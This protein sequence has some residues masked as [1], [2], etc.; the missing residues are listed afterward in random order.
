MFYKVFYIWKYQR[1]AI[2]LRLC[3]VSVKR[4]CTL[5]SNRFSPEKSDIKGKK[6][7]SFL[8]LFQQRVFRFSLLSLL[9]GNVR[10]EKKSSLRVKKCWFV[11]KIV[12]KKEKN[13]HP[14]NKD[15]LFSMVDI[16]GKGLRLIN[17]QQIKKRENRVKV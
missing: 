5:S 10:E 7:N 16:K 14:S 11:K 6:Y 4:L 12:Q 15:R 2:L 1:N 9:T 17:S 8:W 13:V 3:H